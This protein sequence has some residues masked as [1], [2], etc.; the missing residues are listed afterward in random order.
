MQRLRL[1][2][3]GDFTDML[4]INKAP[5]KNNGLDCAHYEEQIA[6]LN[7][8]LIEVDDERVRQSMQHK[9]KISE[10]DDEYS[11]LYR[12]LEGTKAESERSKAK[13]RSGSQNKKKVL[14][15]VERPKSNTV[16]RA[17]SSPNFEFRENE[18]SV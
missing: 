18:H 16:L 3:P 5:S 15:E 7:K 13:N 14:E 17:S 11:H 10:L 4:K 8:A 6:R 2:I 9:Y 12:L 1:Q